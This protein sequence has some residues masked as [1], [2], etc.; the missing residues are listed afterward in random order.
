MR[1]LFDQGVPAPLREALLKDEV[2]TCHERGMSHFSNGELI[3]KA[4]FEYDAFVTTD[5]NLGYQQNLKWRRIAILV[6]PTT[7]WPV[8]KPHCSQIA[9]VI[10]VLQEGK[11]QEWALP[12]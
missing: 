5:K 6:L 1:V 4:E 11:F 9:N 3:A 10:G 12:D 2:D 7:R 8:L